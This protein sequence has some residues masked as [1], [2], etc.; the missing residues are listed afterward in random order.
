MRLLFYCL[1]PN[2]KQAF[3]NDLQVCLDHTR[4]DNHTIAPEILFA[5]VPSAFVFALCMLRGQIELDLSI[6]CRRIC[7]GE[8]T[9]ATKLMKVPLT[10]VKGLGKGTAGMLRRSVHGHYHLPLVRRVIRQH[11]SGFLHFSLVLAL[12]LF[13]LLPRRSRF[14]RNRRALPEC[15]KIA[16]HR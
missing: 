9:G 1:R 11:R 5:F 15:F 13:G 3:Y 4:F 7:P 12:E 2:N 8:F 14:F 6:R 16:W 10:G